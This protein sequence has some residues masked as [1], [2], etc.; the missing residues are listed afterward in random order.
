MKQSFS[1]EEF[2]KALAEGSLKE[3]IILS[4]IVKPSEDLQ[5]I[6]FSPGKSC[7]QWLLIPVEIIDKVEHQGKV[8]CRDHTYDYVRI[9]LKAVIDGPVPNALLDLLRSYTQTVAQLQQP[10]PI[11]PMG[12]CPCVTGVQRPPITDIQGSP[13]TGVQRPPIMKAPVNP[14]DDYGDCVIYSFGR[15]YYT[16]CTT[17]A[18][19][20]WNCGQLQQMHP[21]LDVTCAWFNSNCNVG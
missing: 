4:G 8:P 6:L 16:F 7:Q 15:P 9:F 5:V 18:F 3:P 1:G 14:F 20:D 13:V 19:C 17:Y 2:A 12:Q 21:E 10:L 11:Q